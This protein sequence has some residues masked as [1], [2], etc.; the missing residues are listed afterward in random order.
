[1]RHAHRH[2]ADLE[3]VGARALGS[4]RVARVGDRRGGQDVATIEVRGVRLVTECKYRRRLPRLIVDGLDQ[5]QRYDTGAEPMLIIRE[6]RGRA[7]LVLDLEVGCR[8]L[9]IEGA[10]LP[11]KHAP[12]RRAKHDRQVALFAESS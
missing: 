5:A 1:M 3:R 2:G 11:T 4:R 12:T 9:G 10:E 7:L 8:L 6:H